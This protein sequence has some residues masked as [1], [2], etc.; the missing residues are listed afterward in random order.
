[1]RIVH[2]YKDYFPPTVGGIEQSVGRLAVAG[3]RAGNDVTVLTSNPG[4]RATVRETIDG[5]RVIRCGEWRRALSTPFCP[6]MPGELG[7]LEADVVHL[8]YPSPP[9]EVSCLLARPRAAIVVTYY[10]D[11]VRQKAVLPIYGHVIRAIM[12]SADAILP[13]YEGQ[14]EASAFVR[15]HLD[16]CH[17]APFGSDLAP[18]AAGPERERVTAAIR[19]THGSPLLVFVGRLVTYKGVDVLLRAMPGVAARLL[20]VGSGPEEERLRALAQRL[21]LGERVAFLGRVDAADL[22]GIMAAADVGVLPSVTRAEAFGLSMVE[23]MSCGV[24]MVCTEVGTAT[25][26]VNRDG[27][28]GLVV[29]PGDPVR[30]AEALNRLLGDASLRREMGARASER[31][32]TLFDFG[33]VERRVADVY[34]AALAHRDARTRPGRS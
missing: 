34:A 33:Q 13:I 23:M 26:F 2:L 28:T 19:A 11:I 18:F 14:A 32:R 17:V 16:K 20:V 15:P 25:S 3:A 1:M 5:V 21:D 4:S 30:L 7:K 31:A 24:P 8:H 6:G 12:R 29:P 9:G 27:E 22:P 10:C